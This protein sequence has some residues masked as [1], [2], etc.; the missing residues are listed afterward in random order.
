MVSLLVY[1]YIATTFFFAER[2]QQVFVCPGQSIDTSQ[3]SRRFFAVDRTLFKACFIL[4][5]LVAIGIDANSEIVLL[6]WAIVESEN[7]PSLE[8]F[9]QH[10]RWSIPS[11]YIGVCHY[12]L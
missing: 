12:Y 3:L 6:G 2:F 10:L 7:G 5:L 8:W 9:L 11:L 4:T 1:I